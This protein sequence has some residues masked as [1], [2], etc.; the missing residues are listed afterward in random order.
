MLDKDNTTYRLRLPCGDVEEV[1]KLARSESVRRGHDV[2]WCD[3]IRAA[4]RR[5]AIEQRPID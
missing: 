4:L 3:L 5:M 1:R 2:G